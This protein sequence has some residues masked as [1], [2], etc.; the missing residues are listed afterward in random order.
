[1]LPGG[2]QFGFDEATYTRF[3]MHGPGL[4][5]EFN[6]CFSDRYGKAVAEAFLDALHNTPKE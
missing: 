5:I 4:S 6:G 3:T 1:M 2:S